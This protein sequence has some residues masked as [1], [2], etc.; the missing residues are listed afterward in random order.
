[1]VI[2]RTQGFMITRGMLT[3]AYDGLYDICAFAWGLIAAYHRVYPYTFLYI[4]FSL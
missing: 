1:M 4:C 3:G 2:N